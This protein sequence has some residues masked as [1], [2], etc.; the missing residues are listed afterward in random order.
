[1]NTPPLATTLSTKEGLGDVEEDGLIVT[2]CIIIV[3]DSEEPNY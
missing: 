2:N 1:M 3:L